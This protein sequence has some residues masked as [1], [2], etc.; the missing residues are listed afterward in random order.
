MVRKITSH[1]RPGGADTKII[2]RLRYALLG[3]IHFINRQSPMSSRHVVHA[4][5][6]G[7]MVDSDENDNDERCGAVAIPISKR[8]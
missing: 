2:F 1:G 8:T 3:P 4:F 5:R 6:Y 7:R